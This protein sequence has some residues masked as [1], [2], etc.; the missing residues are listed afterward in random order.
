[1]RKNFYILQITVLDPVTVL[2]PFA[3]IHEALSKT[4]DS[5]KGRCICIFITAQRMSRVFLFF[6]IIIIIV[7]RR[8]LLPGV[9]T[10]FRD[11]D[12]R[13][14]LGASNHYYLLFL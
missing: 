3:K 7:M 5:Y 2:V 8:S 13:P 11:L 1:M 12:R 10:L 6:F 14:I 9:T 4:N